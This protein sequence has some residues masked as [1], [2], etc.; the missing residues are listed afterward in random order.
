MTEIVEAHVAGADTREAAQT[1][2][3]RRAMGAAGFIAAPAI[4][5]ALTSPGAWLGELGI[6]SSFK[7]WTTLLVF[8]VGGAVAIGAYR[9]PLPNGLLSMSG[10]AED[11]DALR[12]PPGAGAVLIAMLGAFV[13]AAQKDRGLALLLFAFMPLLAGWTIGRAA[14]LAAGSCVSRIAPA[15]GGMVLSG[16]FAGHIGAAHLSGIAGGSGFDDAARWTVAYAMAS[17]ALLFAARASLPQDRLRAH[18]RLTATAAVIK[19][20]ARDD[21]GAIIVPP[22]AVEGMTIQFG[23]NVILDRVDVDVPAGTVVALVGANGAGKSTLLRA[24]AGFITPK[25]G[26]IL[27]GGEDVT[28]LRAEE[29]ADAGLAF[30]SGARPV[31]PD[32]TVLENLRVAAFRSH[33]SGRSF[34]SATDAVMDAV[35]VLA[36]RRKDKAGVLSGGE[37]R[38]LAVA[39]TL[40]RKPDVLLADELSLGLDLPSR[41][42]VLDLLRFLADEGVAVMVVDHDLP[43]LLP[44]AD[45]AVLLS[46]GTTQV[47]A[48]PERL[49]DRRND[50]LPATFLAEAAV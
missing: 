41:I 2:T 9:K 42:S 16:V 32:L 23:S 18:A 22:L 10:K 7:P 48:K 28:T 11:D 47:F 34:V 30:V 8:F 3:V 49:L 14:R 33:L 46:A 4:A 17:G 50:L 25:T 39:Q 27:V 19:E 21:A 13:I 20:R 43:S 24:A 35:P 1:A 5:V 29:R 6:R 31:F 15:T 12:L 26:R 36:G 37:Q 40:Y 38:L 45:Q 44:R